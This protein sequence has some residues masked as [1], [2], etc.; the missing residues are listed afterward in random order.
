MA[1]AGLKQQP[2]K[3]PRRNPPLVQIQ[4][5][6]PTMNSLKQW[7]IDN[8]YGSIIGMLFQYGIWLLLI[9]AI[10]LDVYMVLIA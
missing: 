6:P 10:V 4:L 3:L 7:I 1:E 5:F 9:I 8:H 2:T